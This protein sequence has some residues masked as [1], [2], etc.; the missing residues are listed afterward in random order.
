MITFVYHYAGFLWATK[1]NQ[2]LV[3]TA[4]LITLLFNLSTV[5]LLARKS[6]PQLPTIKLSIAVNGCADLRGQ[7]VG[8]PQDPGSMTS[9]A[10]SPIADNVV[11]GG[12]ANDTCEATR[13]DSP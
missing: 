7:A 6:P 4:R 11:S 12:G 5:E 2:R 10:P 8:A 9:A 13:S 1:K 3:W